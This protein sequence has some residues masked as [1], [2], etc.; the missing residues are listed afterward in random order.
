LAKVEPF[1]RNFEKPRYRLF[2][3][4]SSAQQFVSSAREHFVHF[5]G[6]VKQAGWNFFWAAEEHGLNAD[7]FF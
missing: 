1:Y 2:A 4:Q 5:A 7:Y 3:F 6:Q